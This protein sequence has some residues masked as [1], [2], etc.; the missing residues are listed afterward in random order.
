[1]GRAFKKRS[2]RLTKSGLKRSSTRING[3]SSIWRFRTIGSVKLFI[4]TREKLILTA[5]GCYRGSA[6]FVWAD[7]KPAD[8]RRSVNET[9]HGDF[10]AFPT[11]PAIYSRNSLVSGPT[12]ADLDPCALRLRGTSGQQT[13]HVRPKSGHSWPRGCQTDFLARAST[14]ST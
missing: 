13:E 7:Q 10:D 2:N 11:H 12:R 3:R 4:S 8:H 1:N 9:P 5:E 6:Y 14:L